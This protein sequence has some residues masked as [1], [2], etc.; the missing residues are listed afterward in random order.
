MSEPLVRDVDYVAELLSQTPEFI[1]S[2][3]RKGKINA[4]KMGKRWMIPQSELNRL[5][6]IE[7][8][9]GSQKTELIITKLEA[10]NRELRYQLT[11]IKSFLTGANS[12]LGNQ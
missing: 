12:M 5:L 7:P 9:S 8:T 10:E 3:C 1:R 4:Q 11:A 2:Q 6:H